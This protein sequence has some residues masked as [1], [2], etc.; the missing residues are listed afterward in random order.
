MQGYRYHDA[1]AT[2]IN[3]S[4]IQNFEKI[5]ALKINARAIDLSP[6]RRGPGFKTLIPESKP[7]SYPRPRVIYNRSRFSRSFWVIE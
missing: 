5:Y 1:M 2:E 4:C 7:S 6:S 3:A